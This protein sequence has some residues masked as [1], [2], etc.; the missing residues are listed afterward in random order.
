MTD[1]ILDEFASIFCPKSQAVIRASV[2]P[3]NFSGI[4]RASC[5][6]FIMGLKQLELLELHKNTLLREV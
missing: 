2:D 1:D 6:N 4:L 5:R 3:Q